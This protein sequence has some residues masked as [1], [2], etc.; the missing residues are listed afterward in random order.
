M[1]EII[2]VIQDFANQMTTEYNVREV[3]V[4]DSLNKIYGSPLNSLMLERY[5]SLSR[6]TIFKDNEKSSMVSHIKTDEKLYIIVLASNSP[7]AFDGI[8]SQYIINQILILKRKLG[9][10][11]WI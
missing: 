11:R 1:N 7:E 3:I 5:L 2:A 8:E 4:Y 6:T 9:E 10:V